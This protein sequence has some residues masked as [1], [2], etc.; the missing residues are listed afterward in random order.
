MASSILLVEDDPDAL[1]FG[2]LVLRE[3]GYQ[4]T[5]APSYEEGRRGL[6][7]EPD[8]LITDIRLGAFNGLQLVVHARTAWPS[9]PILVLTGFHDP[10]LQAEAERLE[11]R[12]LCKPID[13]DQLVQAVNQGFAAAQ[14]QAHS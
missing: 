5:G 12:Y 2:L 6:Q 3:A 8:M 1:D 9:L 10:L 7:A 13:A 11:A 14:S 4:V